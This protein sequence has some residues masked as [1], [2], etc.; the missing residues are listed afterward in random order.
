VVE[1]LKG[2]F[3]I[4]DAD[5]SL[6]I[7]DKL[8]QKILRQDTR[9]HSHLPALLALFDVSS[10]DP[11]WLALEP[12]Q[13]RQRTIDAVRQVLLQE[14]LA[15]PLLVI[16]EDLHWIDTE[17]QGLLDSLA[18]AV[19]AARVVL[20]VTYRPEYQHHWGA[21]TYYTQLR[22]DPLTG[23][24][25]DVL[26]RLL[27]GDDAS[28]PPLKR[29]LIER[30]EGNPLFLEESVRALAETGTLQG[31]RGEYRLSAPAAT[32]DVPATVQ[33]I[34][35]AR[36][37]RLSGEEKRLL[38]AAAVIGKDVPYPLLQAIA[39]LPEEQLRQ[40]LADLQRAEFLYEAATYPDLAYTFK[41][42]LTHDV[43]YG[44][45]SP[46]RRRSLHRRIMEAIER[47]YAGRLAEQL[48]RLGYHAFRAEAWDRAVAYLRQ[49]GEKAYNRSANRE[50]AAWFE[51]ALDALS[52]CPE[53]P[54]WISQAID[55]R[56]DLRSALH[57]QGEFKRILDALQEAQRL[58]E[59]AGDQQR[60]A[61]GLG[62]LALTFAFTGVPDRALAAGHRALEIAEE[63]G[64]RGLAV[65][66]NCAL[67]LIYFQRS[68]YRR[69]MDFN[70]SNIEAL[71]GVLARERL[72][73]P[74]FPAVYSRHLAI[75]SLAPMGEFDEATTRAKEGFEIANAVGH[76]LSELYMYMA[77]GFLHTYRGH[78]AEAIRLLEHGRMLC[79]VTGARLIFAW[80]SSYLGLAYTHSG[81]ILDGVS[82]LEQG[83]ETVTA[84]RVMLRR[85]LV[86]GWLGEAYLSAGRTH[87]AADCAGKAL[88][89]AREQQER[90]HE[91]EALRL[92][93]DISVCRGGR[94][95]EASADSYRQ[96]LDLAK[97]LGM[98]PLLARCHL[99]LGTM[100]LRTGDP[101]NAQGHLTTAVDMFRAMGMQH[102]L[103]KAAGEMA[104]LRL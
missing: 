47:L 34:L 89:L 9:L 56:F 66:T 72:G 74:V 82:H 43:A 81:R 7:R 13:R 79:E 62:Y 94:E 92:L 101:V 97:E 84:L 38:Q 40:G 45:V 98:R 1:L 59:L 90:G 96:A 16:F 91:A 87:D 51:Q 28:L 50:A 54:D 100:H 58:A 95:T 21:K 77:D 36:I 11:L 76:P 8:S 5:T 29:L 85:S 4:D 86:I 18:E 19:P 80:V 30:T 41:H 3:H 44:G 67:G 63:I 60:L 78:F 68:D 65:A 104:D 49:S 83:I 102:W 35:A 33:A 31:S 6:Q 42:A 75:K 61:R 23:E 53:G 37:D 27:V 71:Q 20:L 15:Q 57:P 10:D 2:Y 103:E 24:N 70:N 17:T 52:H 73:M 26:L 22:I 12:P 93:G 48:E 88:D 69:S 32:L 46:E 14:S 99:G 55:L 64:E 25:A 39:E